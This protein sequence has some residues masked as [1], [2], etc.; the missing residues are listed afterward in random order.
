MASAPYIYWSL[1][2]FNSARLVLF[3]PIIHVWLKF[4]VSNKTGCP[5]LPPPA[6]ILIFWLL[7]WSHNAAALIKHRWIV[8]LNKNQH[9]TIAQKW[10]VAMLSLSSTLQS[11]LGS[12]SQPIYQS[13]FLALWKGTLIFFFAVVI[14]DNFVVMG[15]RGSWLWRFE[16][17]RKKINRMSLKKYFSEISGSGQ[18]WLF[19]K[20]RD[21]FGLLR[22]KVQC[23]VLKIS[24]WI[25][26]EGKLI[27]YRIFSVYQKNTKIIHLIM[28]IWLVS[29][30]ISNYKLASGPPKDPGGNKKIFSKSKDI[31]S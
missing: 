20:I 4:Y 21:R 27:S 8:A 1:F 28:M 18:F 19:W 31:D 13:D 2:S 16:G 30:I 5:L 26:L 23:S 15:E 9:Q 24:L 12:L 11:I 7:A 6:R 14:V 10:C 3:I 22:P 17:K 29:F 25:V